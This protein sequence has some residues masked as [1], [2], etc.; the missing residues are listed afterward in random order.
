MSQR[1][2]IGPR[3]AVGLL[4]LAAVLTLAACATST[5]ESES[6]GSPSAVATPT[7][8]PPPSAPTATAPSTEDP[9]ELVAHA[10]NL[11]GT[12]VARSGADYQTRSLWGVSCDHDECNPSVLVTTSGD[13]ASDRYR[14]G[15]HDQL[16][17]GIWSSKPP[18]AP[19][20]GGC[21]TSVGNVTLCV[22]SDWGLTRTD[23]AGHTWEA[24]SNPF[25]DRLM[26][27]PLV[28]LAPGVDAVAGGGDGATLFPFEQVA[29]LRSPDD[30]TSFHLAK[31]A[32]AMGY[33]SGAV[34]LSDGRILTLLADWS[35]D[36]GRLS[37]RHHGLW[38]SDGDNWAS[39][40][41]V[42]PVF[43]P[44]LTPPAPK[45]TALR[46]LSASVDPD[47]VIWVQTWDYRVYVSTDDAASFQ[48]LRIR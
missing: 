6:A 29:R 12:Y 39:Y 41:P 11:S 44:P 30:V 9:A 28:S 10:D 18:G 43:S 26:Q 31:Q 40:T 34:V 22:G 5:A 1:Q 4:A 45:T 37:D 25:V 35:D 33:T 15:T 27:M 36:R 3:H 46:V 14:V 2:T 20:V 48:E 19:A 47:A 32:G 17:R 8:T 7:P 24:V 16:Q 21:A 23:D 13:P 38:V 42:E